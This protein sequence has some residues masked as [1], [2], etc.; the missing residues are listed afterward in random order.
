MGYVAKK[1]LILRI[2]IFTCGINNYKT[3][4]IFLII[5][6]GCA[7]VKSTLSYASRHSDRMGVPLFDLLIVP[8]YVQKVTL[9][10]CPES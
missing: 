8:K 7:Y 9:D 6:D 2:H 1:F 5:P 3:L 10:K 4:S